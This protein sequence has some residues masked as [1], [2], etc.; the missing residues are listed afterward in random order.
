MIRFPR[1]RRLRAFT[2]IELLTVV[3][4]IGIVLA[5]GIPSAHHLSG[6]GRVTAAA[7]ALVHHL[8]YAR[9]EAIRLV[10]A[11]VLC[12]SRDG[13]SCA[14][15]IEWQ[16]GF[17]LF[18]DSNQNRVRDIGE[19]LLKFKRLEDAGVRVYSSIG[20]KKLIYQATGM[21]PGS[22]ATITVCDRHGYVAPKAVILSNP[23]RPRLSRTRANGS[24]L[25]C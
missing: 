21:A 6:N 22:T 5:I 25:E 12:P 4:M 10:T 24:A 1:H 20:R 9:S 14:D 2:L 23:G 8:H 11:V 3:A 19:T 13:S 18:A 17:I 15:A 7:N 16:D